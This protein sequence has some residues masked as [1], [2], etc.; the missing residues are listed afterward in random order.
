MKHLI[1]LLTLLPFFT[2]CGQQ[3][4]EKKEETGD[5]QKTETANEAPPRNQKA[6]YYLLRH[7]EKER[8]DPDHP[9]PALNRA[10]LLR[11]KRWAPYFEPSKTAATYVTKYVRT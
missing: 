4:D 11:A 8:T 3:K 5:S 7:A 1:L 9:Y 6:T 2:F 10:G